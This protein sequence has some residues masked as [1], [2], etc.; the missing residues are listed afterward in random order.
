MLTMELNEYMNANNVPLSAIADGKKIKSSYLSQIKNGKKI[1]SPKI[2]RII[3]E[4]IKKLGG[5]VTELEL[6]YPEKKG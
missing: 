1:P 6:L 4:R 2:A 3:S 5:S